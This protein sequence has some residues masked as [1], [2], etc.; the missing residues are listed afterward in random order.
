MWR[1]GT[2]A[3]AG[4][5]RFLASRVFAVLGRLRMVPVMA[6]GQP[7]FAVYQREPDGV[8]RAH[9][10]LVPTLAATGIARIVVFLDPGLVTAFGLPQESGAGA[11]APGGA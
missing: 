10:V 4:V 6:N 3:V 8:F 5:L 9:E 1:V 2:L 11:P 7:A